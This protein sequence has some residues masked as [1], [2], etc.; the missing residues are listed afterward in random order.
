MQPRNHQKR[1]RQS[2]LH[3]ALILTVSMILVKLI[4][5][6]FKIPLTWIITEEGLGYF[7]TAYHFYSPI[8]SLATAGFPIAIAR[9]VSENLACGRY[10]DVRRIHKLSIPIFLITGGLG[11]AVMVISAPFY[12]RAI[13]NGGALPAMFCL[14]PAILFSCLSSV[15]RG[16]YEGMSNMYPT[17]ISEVME[18]I[19]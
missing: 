17:A 9:M 13:G 1:K 10:A 15:Y 5:A 12:V 6:M 16:Y 7:N 3:G 11:L 4:G 19:F 14:A 2:F 8:H 18:A